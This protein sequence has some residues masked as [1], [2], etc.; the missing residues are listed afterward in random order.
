MTI[1]KEYILQL[2]N[3]IKELKEERDKINFTLGILQAEFNGVVSQALREEHEEN[4]KSS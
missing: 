2:G 3:R 1:R 4:H